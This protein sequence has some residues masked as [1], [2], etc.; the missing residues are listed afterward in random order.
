MP[1]LPPWFPR[2]T[3]GAV[4]AFLYVVLATCVVLS[5]RKGGGGGWISLSGMASF[6]ITFPVSLAGELLGMKPDFRRNLDMAFAIIVCA[7]LVYLLGAGLG[8]LAR[9]MFSGGG[10]W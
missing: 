6:L 7:G 2:S 4:L 1:A 3:C 9:L 8:K 10:T 5:D